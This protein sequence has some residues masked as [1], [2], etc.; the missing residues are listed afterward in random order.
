MGERGRSR[1]P[2]ESDADDDDSSTSYASYDSADDDDSYEDISKMKLEPVVESNESTDYESDAYSSASDSIIE[3]PTPDASE[4]ESFTDDFPTPGSNDMGNRKNAPS[5]SSRS[6]PES[7][8]FE[9]ETDHFEGDSQGEFAEDAASFGKNNDPSDNED[10]RESGDDTLGEEVKSGKKDDNL[11]WKRYGYSERMDSLQASG[12]EFGDEST[13]F[14]ES[15]SNGSGDESDDKSDF[16]DGDTFDDEMYT[17]A[18]PSIAGQMYEDS[19][20]K[21]T[22]KK[23]GG[24]GGAFVEKIKG[25]LKSCF[26]C[27]GLLEG[28]FKWYLLG[29]IILLCIAV[30]LAV[31]LGKEDK[32][33]TTKSPTAAPLIS[34]PPTLPQGQV[35]EKIGFFAL[36]PNGKEDEI[37]KEDLELEFS[38]AFD[39][40][41]P[42]LLLT[43]IEPN[44]DI[45]NDSS[46]LP[47]KKTAIVSEEKEN[48]PVRLRGRRRR[49]HRKLEAL[50]VKLPIPVTIVEIMCPETVSDPD[51]DMCVRAAADIVVIT[52]DGTIGFDFKAAMVVAIEDEKLQAASDAT[53]SNLTIMIL[54]EGTISTPSPTTIPSPT[55]SPRPTTSSAPTSSC[56]DRESSCEDWAKQ[57]PNEC[58]V[59]PE[60][61]GYYCTKAC[62]VCVTESPTTA[63]PNRLPTES[64]T[65][66]PTTSASS[67]DVP[68]ISSSNLPTVSSFNLISVFPTPS[69]SAVEAPSGSVQPTNNDNVS[70]TSSSCVDK[71]DECAEFFDDGLCLF[72]K[73]TLWTTEGECDTNSIFMLENCAQSCNKC[74]ELPTVSPTPFKDPGFESNAPT[75]TSAPTNIACVDNNNRCPEW[76]A[77]G[78]CSTNPGYM[79]ENCK[80]SCGVCQN[81][82]DD[83]LSPTSSPNDELSPT[84]SPCIDKNDRC[85]EWAAGDQCSSNPGYMLENC[86]LSCNDC[87]SEGND[88]P[89]PVLS[90]CTDNN[91]RCAEWS[92]D[93]QCSSNPGYMLKNCKLSCD[94]CES[95]GE[96][97]S[98]T[99]PSSCADNNDRCPEWAADGQCSV[100]QGYM[101]ENCKASCGACGDSDG[102]GS[103]ITEFEGTECIDKKKDCH[104]SSESGECLK[105]KCAFWTQ[106]GECEANPTYMTDSCVKSCGKC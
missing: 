3:P 28:N 35:M 105:T 102:T 13:P 104:E 99:P 62:G 77:D 97:A 75:S 87:E 57:D 21:E 50:S 46:T 84:S 65:A 16:D 25:T 78:Q 47:E 58:D 15:D 10:S 90:S 106:E 55:I 51:I 33:D 81:L 32:V 63:S 12:S 37:T 56:Y 61:M 7:D 59:N 88:Q 23:S 9:D 53:G 80:L 76:V 17:S 49:R 72:T 69:T 14:E 36:I 67:V 89:S 34:S 40:L 71:N 52:D 86:K 19:E 74:D 26:D 66:S 8:E 94:A 93:G 79:L 39:I 70:P 22:K 73:C 4:Y 38:A 41:A 30:V 24:G 100:N 6:E 82:G 45:E 101:L 2:R 5:V 83:Q 91:N 48:D 54:E 18:F 11:F 60:Y 95:S 1:E 68:T 27:S 44:G 96:L 43:D 42:Q 85:A 31:V 103:D 92:G 29:A 64:P 20:R 98:T